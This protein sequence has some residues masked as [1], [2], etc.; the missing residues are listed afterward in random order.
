MKVKVPSPGHQP[1][2]EYQSLVRR[3]RIEL[4]QLK[5]DLT[6]SEMNLES[7]A[8]TLED[9]LQ[10][11]RSLHDLQNGPPLIRDRKEYHEVM[12]KVADFLKMNESNLEL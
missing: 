1:C 9:A 11:L 5:S 12:G 10:L 8:S 6:N 4:D 3:L 7:V 2:A